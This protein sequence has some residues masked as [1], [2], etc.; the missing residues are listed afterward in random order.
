MSE[1]VAKKIRCPE[2][3]SH[4]VDAETIAVRGVSCGWWI[5]IFIGLLLGVAPGVILIIALV[6]WAMQPMKFD[7]DCE[8]C[9]H[10]W[11]EDVSS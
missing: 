9:G 6:I 8:Q 7:C 1:D 5:V 2:C 3:G 10:S 4:K 11:I